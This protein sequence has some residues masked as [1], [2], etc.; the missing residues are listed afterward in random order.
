MKWLWW[1]PDFKHGGSPFSHLPKKAIAPVYHSLRDLIDERSKSKDDLYWNSIIDPK[2]GSYFGSTFFYPYF[3]DGDLAIDPNVEDFDYYDGIILGE[4]ISSIS[5]LKNVRKY[6]GITIGVPRMPTK[7]LK[8][9]DIEMVDICLIGFETPRDSLKNLN[10]RF[11][12]DKWNLLPLPPCDVEFLRDNF[13]RKVEEKKERVISYR[14]SSGYPNQFVTLRE[15]GKYLRAFQK[16]MKIP[17]YMTSSKRKNIPPPFIGKDIRKLDDY[18]KFISESRVSILASSTGGS[19]V[20]LSAGCGTLCVGSI[21]TTV[22]RLIFPDL[23]FPPEEYSKIAHMI[24]KCFEDKEFYKEEQRKALE[25]LM[26]W[27]RKDMVK[28]SFYSILNMKGFI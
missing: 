6:N 27:F 23:S 18:Y 2:R 1:A 24:K 28:R 3:L 17:G 26:F 20:T 11:K 22:Q 16:L 14:V 10:E 19:L 7:S 8:K 5:Y 12:T 13:Y 9:K 21:E 15:T 25:N 4:C